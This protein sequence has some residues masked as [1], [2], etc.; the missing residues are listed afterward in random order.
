M[1]EN[2]ESNSIPWWGWLLIVVIG[3]WW[4]VDGFGAF[5]GNFYSTLLIFSLIF[6]R[7]NTSVEEEK[8]KE[9]KRKLYKNKKKQI[10][11]L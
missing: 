2:E 4:L 7:F 5:G 10:K 1:V 8:L 11:M 3:L 9:K 6:T